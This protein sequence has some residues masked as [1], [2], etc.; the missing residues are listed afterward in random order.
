MSP[1]LIG[2]IV[3]AIVAGL[4]LLYSAIVTSVNTTGWPQWHHN[5]GGGS[6]NTW[7]LMLVTSVAS[8]AVGGAIG[9]L[10]AF[11]LQLAFS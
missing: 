6:G 1:I 11:L 5:G 8:G 9:A 7:R 10:V 2:F 4:A 3:G